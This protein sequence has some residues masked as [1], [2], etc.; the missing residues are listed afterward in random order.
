MTKNQVVYYVFAF[1]L[2]ILFLLLAINF[3]LIPYRGSNLPVELVAKN[4]KIIPNLIA[5]IVGF[6]SMVWVI[7]GFLLWKTD[8]FK[9]GQ[10]K[11]MELYLNHGKLAFIAGIIGTTL[12]AI[13]FLFLKR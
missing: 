12:S 1:S 5:F 2:P 9:R 8:F 4:N 6:W 7:Q 11:G 3:N 10:F 13:Y